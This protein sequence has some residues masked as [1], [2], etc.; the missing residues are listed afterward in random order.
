MIVSIVLGI[1]G[2]VLIFIGLA[3]LV[4]DNDDFITLFGFGGFF[5]LLALI[6]VLDIIN[7]VCGK[8]KDLVKP[9]VFHKMDLE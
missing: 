4:D 2:L 3:N 1:I 7:V 8:N 6:I 9:Y 5:L